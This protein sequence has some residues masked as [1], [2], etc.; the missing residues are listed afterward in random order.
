VAAKLRE[1]RNVQLW[2]HDIAG[3]N[4]LARAEKYF[5]QVVRTPLVRTN[6]LRHQLH[7]LV[8][9]R[10]AIAHANGRLE[11]LRE[12]HKRQIRRLLDDPKSGVADLDGY[13]AVT[14]ELVDQLYAGVKGALEPLFHVAATSTLKG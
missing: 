1:Q 13:L 11:S 3:D 12:D 6:D 8:S 7:V 14:P 9:L 10:H 5:V 2:L 4:F